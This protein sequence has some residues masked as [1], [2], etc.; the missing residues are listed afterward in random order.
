MTMAEA[1]CSLSDESMRVAEEGIRGMI[2]TAGA[3][4]TSYVMIEAALHILAAWAAA[5]ETKSTDAGRDGNV[6]E[7]KGLLSSF[8]DYHRA[9][10]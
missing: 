3:T 9:A 6:E 5:S 10:K 4:V 2:K 7:L 1:S 8:V